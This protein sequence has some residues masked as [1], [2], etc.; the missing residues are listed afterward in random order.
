[1]SRVLLFDVMGTL[2]RD[3][4]FVEVPA[5]FG[6][7]LQELIAAKHPTAWV[8]FELGEIDDEGLARRFFTDGRRLDVDG[9]RRAMQAGYELLP[10]I[11]ELLGELRARQQP[12]HVLSNYPHWYRLIEDRLALS[13]FLPWT[14]VSCHT[15]VRKPDA[16]AYLGA[17]AALGV[18]PEACVFVDDRRDNCEAARAVGMD[19]IRFRDAAALREAL[20]DRG[21]LPRP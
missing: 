7:A 6:V 15:R 8:D 9:L 2:V 18:A 10:G 1:M 3:P 17:A 13:R 19:A 14:F 16:R 21:L 12:M 5:F 11:E 4:F 20:A